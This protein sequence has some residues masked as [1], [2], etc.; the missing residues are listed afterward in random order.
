MALLQRRYGE[1]ALRR[2]SDLVRPSRPPS[3]PTGFAGLDTLTGC[4]GVPLGALTLLDGR[5]TSGKLTLAYKVLA[6]LHRSPSPNTAA[7]LDLVHTGDPDYLARCDVDLARLLIVRPQSQRPAVDLL[8][9]LVQNR[10]IRAVVVNSL[11]HLV[12]TRPDARYFHNH[13]AQL[14][15]LLRASSCALICLDEPQPP[16]LQWL[17][18]QRRPQ[19]GSWAALHIQ[20]QREAWL[21]E[22]G[23]VTGYQATARLLKSRWARGGGDTAIAICF[24]G[25]V[26][27][28]RTW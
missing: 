9:E 24:N 4:G 12:R 26:R 13:L 25:T 14:N 21:R 6:N 2:G 28:G 5:T 7:L 16:W 22:E 23:R 20:L 3:I 8:L 1:Q 27:A 10:Q 11:S 18:W 19:A 15:L 17:G